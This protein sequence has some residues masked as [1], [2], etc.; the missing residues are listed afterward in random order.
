M[1]CAASKSTENK[2]AKLRHGW[3]IMDPS[4]TQHLKFEY[5]KWIRSCFGIYLPNTHQGRPSL[6]P[7]ILL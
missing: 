5:H 4:S 2:N 1:E 6:L 7:T 3:Q